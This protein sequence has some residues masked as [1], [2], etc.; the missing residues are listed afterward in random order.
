MTLIK[1]SLEEFC[2]KLADSSPTP[3]GGSASAYAGALGVSLYMMV[4]A[5]AMQKAED[6]KPLEELIARLKPHQTRLLQ[7]V[8]LDTQAF[9]AVMTAFRLPKE[10]EEEKALRRQAVQ[11]AMIRAAEVPLETMQV[12][13]AVLNKGEEVVQ[14]GAKAAASDIGVGTKLLIAGLKGAKLNVE[15]NLPSIKDEVVA[16]RLSEAKEQLSNDAR[17]RKKAIWALLA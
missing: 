17:E 7:L 11:K 6:K 2:H 15:I 10:S 5:V 8:D 1:Q 13:L 3:G 12:C 9:D 14:W 16:A 4:L